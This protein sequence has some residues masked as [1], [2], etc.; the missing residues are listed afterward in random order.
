[1]KKSRKLVIVFVII[2]M[3]GT[4]IP[5]AAGIFSNL[6]K[7]N[8]VIK[9]VVENNKIQNSINLNENKDLLK[10][11]KTFINTLYYDKGGYSDYKSVLLKPEKALDKPS[12]DDVRKNTTAQDYFKYDAESL[13]NMMQHML[14]IKQSD[15]V[16][17]YYLKDINSQEEM[18]TAKT[19]TLVKKSGDWL[20]DN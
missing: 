4:L 3:I 7:G 10:P 18:K 12:F 11:I 6:N 2:A 9:P 8:K 16:I 15:K 13:E 1:M 20:I 14:A 17:I 19:W 5:A